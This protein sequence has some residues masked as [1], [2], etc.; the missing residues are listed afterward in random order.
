MPNGLIDNQLFFRMKTSLIF[1]FLF[2][3]LAPLNRVEEADQNIPQQTPKFGALAVHRNNGFY[4]GWSYDQPTLEEAE[5]RAI[6]ECRTRGWDCSVILTYSGGGCA[7][8]R[9]I[10][11]GY[12]TGTAYGWG[13][14]KTR[15]EADRIATN[16]CLKRSNGITPSNFVWSCN[17]DDGSPLKEIYNASSEIIGQA[18]VGRQYWSNRNLD[19]STFRNGDAIPQA[20][21]LEELKKFGEEQKPAWCYF[22]FDEKYAEAYGKYYNWFAVT[23]PRGLAPTGW[24]IPSKEDFDILV[25]TLGGEKTAS[26]KLKAK[27]GWKKNEFRGF[28]PG[29]DEYKFHLLPGGKMVYHYLPLDV[30]ETAYLWTTTPYYNSTTASWAFLDNGE[31][32]FKT[33]MGR[34]DALSVRIIKD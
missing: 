5:K 34:V 3:A 7:A 22:F 30:A 9:A 13:L 25:N 15:E 16:E 2:T 17:S 10:D 26:V 32:L 28:S 6:E 33:D 11:Q 29:T 24:R 19:V 18:L 31:S 14:A 12:Y 23:D 1:F 4:Y 20:K 27:T 21:S 8:F